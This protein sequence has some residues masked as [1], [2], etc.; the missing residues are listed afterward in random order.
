[1]ALVHILDVW[2]K[3]WVPVVQILG[4]W[5][6]YWVS[7]ANTVPLVEIEHMKN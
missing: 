3:Y 2:S 4:V 7:G 6:K 5:S 1:M